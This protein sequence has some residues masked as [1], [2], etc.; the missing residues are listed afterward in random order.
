MDLKYQR[1][2]DLPQFQGV[3]N[4]S[5]FKEL[6]RGWTFLHLAAEN[7]RF[8]SSFLATA[9][10]LDR[11]RQAQDCHFLFN[12]ERYILDICKVITDLALYPWQDI[13]LVQAS[14]DRQD[15]GMWNSVFYGFAM[16]RR[17]EVEIFVKSQFKPLSD[18]SNERWNILLPIWSK[19]DWEELR[20]LL[21][22]QPLT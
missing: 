5:N 12:P 3:P 21:W 8:E 20:G 14:I 1:F 4:P 7:N 6:V 10:G 17:M 13:P 2:V 18:H 16:T 19:I 15:G 11:I 22:T 9:H